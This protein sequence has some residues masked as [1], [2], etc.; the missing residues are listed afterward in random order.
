MR[1]FPA[2]L[3]FCVILAVEGVIVAATG[4]CE[5]LRGTGRD[6]AGCRW[7]LREGGVPCCRPKPGDIV[8]PRL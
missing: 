6:P 3:V 2:R 1:N 5:G 8:A 4:C 7:A